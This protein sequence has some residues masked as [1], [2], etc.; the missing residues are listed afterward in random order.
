MEK[1]EALRVLG[2]DESATDD[3]VKAAFRRLV[4]QVHPD[5]G[6]G[7]P[8]DVQ[9]LEEARD[10]A[11]S[12]GGALIP[13]NQV[14]DLILVSQEPLQRQLE[15][16]GRQADREATF[17]QVV[18]AQT[19]RLR[20][21]QR[22]R[23][24][25]AGLAAGVAAVSQVIRA[26][27]AGNAGSTGSVVASVLLAAF[28]LLAAMLA[29]MAWRASQHVRL[30]EEAVEDAND[31]LSSRPSFVATFREITGGSEATTWTSEE[32]KELIYSW[33]A[34]RTVHE[35]AVSMSYLIGRGDPLPL[36]ALAHEI[37]PA[38][39]LKLLLAKGRELELLQVDESWDDGRLVERY[40]LR[41]PSR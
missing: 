1:A 15:R 7:Q 16:Q 33:S 39:F 5:T 10:A 27:P 2:L 25:Y 32:L 19:S 23:T 41:V 40:S 38:D 28:G 18:R 24:A 34:G 3:E 17:K 6:G 8:A 35:A 9:R 11:L 21:A 22:D 37:R 4:R 20:Q 14:K 36:S 13:V 31:T 29:I 30:I 12:P 26:V